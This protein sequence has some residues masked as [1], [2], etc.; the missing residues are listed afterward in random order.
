MGAGS[1]TL[2]NPMPSKPFKPID[3]AIY[4]ASAIYPVFG[5]T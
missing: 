5:G 4:D 2:P 3:A 1:I